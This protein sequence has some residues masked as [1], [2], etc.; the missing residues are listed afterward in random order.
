MRKIEVV[1]PE[2]AGAWLPFAAPHA[3]VADGAARCRAASPAGASIW[4]QQVELE[5][6]SRLVWDPEHGDEAL[7]VE[8]G[9]LAI[10]GRRCG[11][12]GALVIEAGAAPQ[13]DV[14]S[15]ARI[16]HMGPRDGHRERDAASHWPERATRNATTRATERAATNA[17][18]NSPKVHVVAA[19]GVFETREP[20]RDVRF[21]ADATCPS[22]SLWLL[23]TSRTIA[24]ESPVHTH[25]QDELVHVLH[26]EIQVGSLAAGPGETIFVA[27]NQPY[28]FRAGPGGFGFLNYRQAAS[29]MTIRATGQQIVEAGAATGMTPV[30][31]SLELV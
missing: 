11:A 15:A 23:Y 20:G 6:G 5:P 10:G 8:S 1:R 21:F 31:E 9:E 13:L 14:A 26:G 4:M 30:P 16:L 18:T 19:R 28:Q 7:F 12:G 29:L 17:A 24:Y 27:A 25:S 22:C 3:R 2:R